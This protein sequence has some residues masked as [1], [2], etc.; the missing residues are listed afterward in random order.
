MI[1]FFSSGWLF[2]ILA[3]GIIMSPLAI[4]YIIMYCT[5]FVCGKSDFI[6]GCFGIKIMLLLL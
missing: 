6:F 1:L 2:E 5:L 4:L 3:A